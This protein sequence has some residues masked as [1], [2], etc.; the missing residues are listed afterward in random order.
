MK[1]RISVI[2]PVFNMEKHLSRCVDSILN[3]T[4]REI[5]LILVDDGSTDSSPLICDR[6]MQKDARVK[7]LHQSNGGVSLARNKGLDMATG[8]YI[9][10]VD[11]DDWIEQDM[12]D[13]LMSYLTVSKTDV[14]RFNAIRKDEALNWLPFEG[15]YEGEKLEKEVVLP[16]I[17]TEKFGGMFILGV[18]WIHLFSRELIEQNSIRFNPQL[19]RCE[20]RLFTITAMMFARKV[21]FVNDM[22]YHY[23]VYDE[24]LSNRYDPLRWQQ[25][26]IYLQKLKELYKKNKNTIFVEEADRRIANDCILRVITSVNQEYFSNNRN[27]FCKRYANV[28]EIICCS[29]TKEA[30]EQMQCGK[31]GLKGRLIIDMIKKR[32]AFL[33][34]VLNTMILFKNKLRVNG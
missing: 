17:G 26:R 16:M 32:R 31:V 7:V 21:Q 20:D 30:A 9:S 8:D 1:E 24:S 22:L 29:E 18:L 11:P 25:E 15:V 10:F 34:S 28:K 6:Y 4:Y 3:Q 12:Y 13:R 5:E 14:I 27:S 19:R 33:L 2:V 23:E